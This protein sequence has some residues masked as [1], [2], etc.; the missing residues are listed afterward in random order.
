MQSGYGHKLHVLQ[1]CQEDSSGEG[2]AQD[3]G[4][5]EGRTFASLIMETESQLMTLTVYPAHSH[6]SREGGIRALGEGE[7]SLHA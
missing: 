7:R 6:W 3:T 4:G 5:G 2:Y 1:E